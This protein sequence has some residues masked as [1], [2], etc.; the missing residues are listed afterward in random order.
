LYAVAQADPTAQAGL[1]GITISGP[2]GVVPLDTAFP[3]GTLSPAAQ[4][5]SPSA[6]NL[7][8]SVTDFGF[9]AALGSAS[10]AVTAG[11]TVLGSAVAGTPASVAAPAAAL[12]VWTYATPGS[13]AGTYEVD[14]TSA[15]GSI[16]QAAYGVDNGSALAYA[17]VTPTPLAAGAYQLAANDFQF[18]AALQGLKFA[19]AQGGAILKTAGT[20]GTVSFTAPATLPAVVLVDATTPTNGNGMFDVNVQTSGASP[21]IV[22]DRTQG[23]SATGVFTSQTL[24]LTAAGNF[25]VTVSDLKFPAQ[26]S[27]LALVVSNDGAVVGKIYG[28]GTFT[29]PAT[30]GDYL[31]NFIAQPGGTPAQYG[32][33]GLQ[34]VN[35]APVVTLTASPTTVVTGATTKLTWTTTNATACMASGGAFTG[36]QA[37]SGSASVAVSATT[38]YKLDCTG[39]GGSV[40]GS[41]IVTATAPPAGSSHGGGSLDLWALG[42]LGVLA[43][44][45]LTTMPRHGRR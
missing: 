23:V 38:T 1:Y 45:R 21:Q 24:H 5:N 7:T 20:A 18:P 15:S 4:G 10:A 14:L 32:L 43:S 36:S 16:V 12:Q 25:D 28:G 41:A 2:A 3:V 26:F 33:F 6:Q 35:S 40:T 27:N 8:L 11:G 9:P 13:S 31:V 42:I 17:Y 30:P 29:I 34:V 39:P 44:I 19:V 37:V 22:F